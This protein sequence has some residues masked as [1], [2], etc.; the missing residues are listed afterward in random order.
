VSAWYFENL[1]NNIALD[2][3][4]KYIFNNDL[5]FGMQNDEVKELQKVLMF[6][7]LLNIKEAT[8]YFGNLTLQAVKDYQ[9]L[10]SI[11]PVSGYVGPLTREKLNN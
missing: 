4:E 1:P 6:M 8:G 7:A 3:P 10:N 2:K 11:T 9:A 5:S